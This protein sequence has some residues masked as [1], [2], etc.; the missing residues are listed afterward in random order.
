MSM[1]TDLSMPAPVVSLRASTARIIAGLAFG[2]FVAAAQA[3]SNALRPVATSAAEEALYLERFGRLAG[4]ASGGTGITSYDTMEAL[5]GVR[6][7]RPLPMTPL[8]KSTIDAGALAAAEQY[9]AES[10]SSALLI[11]HRGRLQLERYYGSTERATPI[12]S[13]S[14]AK[15]LSVVAV[16]RAIALGRIRSL[17][18]PVADFVTEWRADPQRSRMTIRH[19]LQMRSGLLR[20]NLATKPED[21][22]NRAYL[23]PRHDEI[24]INEYPLT[25]EP[26]S[27]YEYNQAASELVA[28]IVERATGA[29]Y[30]DF[31]SREVMRRIGAQGGEV[32]VNRPGG[33]AH[34]GCCL[35]TPADT[36]LRLGVLLLQDGVWEGRRLLPADFVARMRAPTEQNP[37][38]GMGVFVPGPYVRRRGFV[39]PQTMPNAPGVL[40]GEPY[41]AADLFL[42]DGSSNQVVYIVPSQQLV[43]ARTGNF[44]P[45]TPGLSEWDNTALPNTIL[46]ALPRR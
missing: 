16:G 30:A 14:L 23:H 27:I 10:D 18:Q 45:K 4:G 34:S 35:M 7:F 11:W 42:F 15:P 43:I 38:Y 9:A 21:I 22:L 39:N 29:R 8:S 2:A 13:R 20:Q 36:W 33:R 3:E 41:A 5:P 19:L 1:R 31:L 32:W 6:R 24:I 46:R 17:D 40:H 44:R 25:N 28:V 26:G 37:Y 12:N